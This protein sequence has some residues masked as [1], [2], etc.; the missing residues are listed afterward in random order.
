MFVKGGNY[1]RSFASDHHQLVKIASTKMNIDFSQIK[2]HGQDRNKSF[3][4]LIYTLFR[5]RKAEAHTHVQRVSDAGGDGGIEAL[6]EDGEAIQAKYIFSSAAKSGLWSQLDKSVKQAIRTYGT[7]LTKYTIYAPCQLGAPK[8]DRKGNK[9]P[10]S[11]EKYVSKWQKLYSEIASEHHEETTL[12]FEFISDDDIRM[13]LLRDEMRDIRRYWFGVNDISISSLREIFDEARANL[14]ERYHEALHVDAEALTYLM[15]FC[16][17]NRALENLIYDAENITRLLAQ[18]K[19]HLEGIEISIPDLSVDDVALALQSSENDTMSFFGNLIDAIVAAMKLLK[20]PVE[21]ESI[22]DGLRRERIYS[23]LEQIQRHSLLFQEMIPGWYSLQK[24]LFLMDGPPGVGKSHHLAELTRKLLMHN[25]PAL[26]FLGAHFSVQQTV[27]QGLVELSR[28]EGNFES[29]METCSGCAEYYGKDFIIII[30]A[31][32]ETSPPRFWLSFLEQLPTISARYP[33]I[34]WIISC[35]E[36]YLSICVPK[37][38]SHIFRDNPWVRYHLGWGEDDWKSLMQRYLDAY[39][40]SYKKYDTYKEIMKSP[41]ELIVIC[42]AF[43]GEKLSEVYPGLLN[44]F[45]LWYTKKVESVA[46]CMDIEIFI[47][48]KAIN[49][50]ALKM[51]D[52]QVLMLSMEDAYNVL[53]GVLH[54]PSH[55]KGLLQNLIG[56]GILKRSTQMRNEY[57]GFPYELLSCYFELIALLPDGHRLDL[58][59][60]ATQAAMCSNPTM[61]ALLTLSCA[62]N[63][64]SELVDVWGKYRKL[65]MLALVRSLKW[66]SEV[67]ILP[68]TRT[69]LRESM[70]MIVRNADSLRE[71]IACLSMRNHPLNAEALAAWLS[72]MPLA[73]L[74]AAWTIPV[75]ILYNE[76]SSVFQNLLSQRTSEIC[77]MG[78]DTARQMALALGYLCGSNTQYLRNRAAFVLSDVLYAH[79]SI[80]EFIVKHFSATI[81]LYLKSHVYAAVCKTILRLSNK[82]VIGGV[83]RKI[84][85]EHTPNS[86]IAF[87]CRRYCELICRRAC[88]VQAIT[89]DEAQE[90]K[91]GLYHVSPL[92]DGISK[93]N[94]KE[95]SH[96]KHWN[97]ILESTRTE[98]DGWYGDFGRYIMTSMLHG[99]TSH[100]IGDVEPTAEDVFDCDLARRI[101]LQLVQEIGW[102]DTLY[103][104]F[105]AFALEYA[106]GAGRSE[107][108]VIRIGKKYQMIA[109]DML[110]A[111]LTDHYIVKDWEW[112][113]RMLTFDLNDFRCMERIDDQPRPDALEISSY[114]RAERQIKEQPWRLMEVAG[115]IDLSDYLY[116]TLGEGKARYILLGGHRIS[117]KHYANVRDMGVHLLLGTKCWL[118]ESK[119]ET[120]FVAH[121]VKEH[122]SGSGIVLDRAYGRC[123]GLYPHDEPIDQEEI[124]EYMWLRDSHIPAYNAA[125]SL[126]FSGD[127]RE[128]AVP[129]RMVME[130]L[131]LSWNDERCAFVSEEAL[132]MTYYSTRPDS[133]QALYIS[134][135]PF[136][137]AA[138][139]NGYTPIIACILEG[140]VFDYKGR[141]HDEG[142]PYIKELL[143][144]VEMNGNIRLVSEQHVLR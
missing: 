23:E 24:K 101:V 59:D 76:T 72:P 29:L 124:K 110:I 16:T 128:I 47:V 92:Y 22:A 30:D 58:I 25:Q 20:T 45:S 57:V 93:E 132:A 65:L 98:K 108:P 120:D 28:Y 42:E 144:R 39:Q 109:L 31:I 141:G 66:R 48:K 36:E 80:V 71:M 90:L 138:Y 139:E 62:S 106:G 95:L 118:V 60:D 4:S 2:N 97:D 91:T 38:S 27:K 34:R 40:V 26:F 122:F 50:I 63:D 119:R 112:L 131:Q 88:L 87:S 81:D 68:R 37:S 79:P 12:K 32:N 17:P 100:T 3:E 104:Q 89:E 13:L 75:T 61:A 85:Q 52:E 49:R 99:I 6:A 33:R 43:S 41:L 137:K 113:D 107:K 5:K 9:K 133:C 70:S 46:V 78:I 136:A 127:E 77:E 15:Y 129:S 96:L 140:H 117:A 51:W 114:V 56:A 35:K 44:I 7:K 116:S 86:G 10:T 82:D 105:D 74:D 69:I 83:A 1:C 94:V 130:F 121:C 53:E 64:H 125:L 73:Q 103:K 14:G 102:N 21:D 11:W 135:E 67:Q 143:Y 19:I 54:T 123:L 18:A 55:S 115:Q 126:S 8:Y 142:S 111:S 84:L 134:A